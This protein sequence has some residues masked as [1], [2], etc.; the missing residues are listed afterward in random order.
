MVGSDWRGQ[1]HNGKRAQAA[2][3]LMTVR[4]RRGAAS[5]RIVAGKPAIDPIR[6]TRNDAAIELLAH[7]D[8][9]ALMDTL[10]QQDRDQLKLLAIFHYIFAALGICGLA[11]MPVHY[12]MMQRMLSMEQT[13]NSA[14]A[15]PEAFLDIF[16]WIYVAMA[17]TFLI[18]MALNVIAAGFLKA[19]KHRTFCMVVAGLNV[20]QVPFGTLLGVFT[21]L[22]LG[23]ESVRQTFESATSASPV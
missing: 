3:I 9:Y 12:T 17:A 8:G 15:P 19:R 5:C 14:N 10:T 22:V 18:G 1:Q 20:L 6:S 23:R 7:S 13:N 21:I 16:I 2:G 11:F 4:Y